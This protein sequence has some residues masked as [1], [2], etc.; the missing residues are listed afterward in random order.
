MLT[1]SPNAKRLPTKADPPQ[2]AHSASWDAHLAKVPSAREENLQA[3]TPEARLAGHVIEVLSSHDNT[4]A[5]A[6]KTYRYRLVRESDGHVIFDQGDFKGKQIGRNMM[7]KAINA[8]YEVN[9]AMTESEESAEPRQPN[10][11]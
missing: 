3:A 8:Q 5:S 6:R 1:D 7:K 4:G 10:T 2:S 9:R 11:Q